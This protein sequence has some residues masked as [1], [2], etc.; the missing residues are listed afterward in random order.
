MRVAND[1]NNTE[2]ERITNKLDTALGS[3][4]DDRNSPLRR[5]PLMCSSNLPMGSTIHV[6]TAL[7]TNPDRS[8]GNTGGRWGATA[9]WMP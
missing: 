7:V 8:S 5:K 2:F 4:D 9:T 6:A 1:N 3:A